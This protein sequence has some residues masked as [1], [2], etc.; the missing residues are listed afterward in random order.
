M[1]LCPAGCCCRNHRHRTHGKSHTHTHTYTRAACVQRSCIPTQHMRQQ[2]HETQGKY[3]WPA[4]GNSV[5]LF[6]TL[7][8]EQILEQEGRTIVVPEPEEMFVPLHVQ[9]KVRPTHLRFCVRPLTSPSLFSS[10]FLPALSLYPLSL[11]FFL[12]LLSLS[13]LSP[14]VQL[15]RTLTEG[16][17]DVKLIRHDGQVY[18]VCTNLQM[19]PKVRVRCACTH[20]RWARTHSAQYAVHG[21]QCNTACTTQFR[22][23]LYPRSARRL[24]APSPSGKL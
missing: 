16:F 22:I 12:L 13:L 5:N 17:E 9:A 19:H 20:S 7:Q 14:A 1:L 8:A 11:F 4:V 23:A 10:H 3:E 21:A 15:R 24:T 2:T 18:G 6:F